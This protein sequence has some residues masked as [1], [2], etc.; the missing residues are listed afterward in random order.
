M[1]DGRTS[2]RHG[3]GLLAVALAFLAVTVSARA[4]WIV[5]G[6]FTDEAVL[7]RDAAVPVW[8]WAA[9]GEIVTVTFGDQRRQA[10]ADRAG[11]WQVTLDPMPASAEGRT[12]TIKGAKGAETVCRNVVVGEVWLCSGQSNMEWSMQ[13]LANN[14]RTGAVLKDVTSSKDPQLRL[15]QVPLGAPQK[16][17]NRAALKDMR[18]RS[19]EHASVA[20]FSGVGYYVGRALRRELK[21]PVGLIQSAWGGTRI[22]AW[23]DA[24]RLSP[25]EPAPKRE[26]FDKNDVGVLFAYMVKPL[27]PYAVRG[28]LWYQGESNRGNGDEYEALLTGMIADWRRLWAQGLPRDAKDRAMWWGVIQLPG[29][30]PFREQPVDDGWSHVCDAQRRVAAADDR[31]GLIVITDLGD[32]KS[33]HPLNKVDVGDRVTG[34]TLANVYRKTQSFGGPEFVKADRDGAAMVV[35]FAHTDGGLRAE[36]KADFRKGAAVAGFTLAGADRK[37]HLAQGTVVAPDAVRVT[38]SEVPEP[39]AV[40]YGWQP[41]PENARLTNHTGIPASP[42]SSVRWPRQ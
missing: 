3:L 13:I 34:W 25:K 38:C 16:D 41:N 8:G 37:W 42:F 29:F 31:V 9:P 33:I 21:V 11:R 6:L 32:A 15:F 4:E 5:P 24:K 23:A 28:V 27:A 7:Q 39:V 19:A 12:L 22:E 2:I 35:H 10:T 40:R 20:P 30:E 1:R 26:Q 14:D 36:A 17:E 18:W